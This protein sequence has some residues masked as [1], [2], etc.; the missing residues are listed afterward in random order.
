MCSS[1]VHACY[2]SVS[3]SPSLVRKVSPSSEGLLEFPACLGSKQISRRYANCRTK[4]SLVGSDR[5]YYLRELG[6]GRTRYA[7][8][9]PSWRSVLKAQGKMYIVKQISFTVHRDSLWIDTSLF[10]K[11]NVIWEICANIRNFQ[12]AG[13]VPTKD[14]RLLWR[15]AKNSTLREAHFTIWSGCCLLGVLCSIALA[16]LAMLASKHRFKFMIN[17]LRD[18]SAMAL[19]RSL[20]LSLFLLFQITTLW[21]RLVTFRQSTKSL[22]WFNYP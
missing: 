2:S 7:R 17:K 19:S 4:L 6:R 9:T 12:Q 21:V 3:Q 22:R 1:R 20:S 13:K 18:L 15:I 16:L 10:V 11:H 14:M 5:P 8:L